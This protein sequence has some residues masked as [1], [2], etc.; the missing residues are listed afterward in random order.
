MLH[1]NI[2][3]VILLTETFRSWMSD[4]TDWNLQVLDECYY[5]LKPSGPGWDMSDTTDWNLQVRDEWYYWLKP[6]GPG[7]VILLTET[8][9]SWMRHEWYYWLKPSG[10]GWVILLTETF[11]SWMSAAGKQLL[12]ILL[13][14]ILFCSF[15]FYPLFFCWKKLAV[16]GLLLAYKCVKEFV[17]FFSIRV[18]TAVWKE[19]RRLNEN[20]FWHSLFVCLFLLCTLSLLKIGCCCLFALVWLCIAVWKEGNGPKDK[21]LALTFYNPAKYVTLAVLQ[22]GLWR[23]SQ[24]SQNQFYLRQVVF[25]CRGKHGADD[26]RMQLQYAQGSNAPRELNTELL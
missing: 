4:T 1:S 22:H 5:W 20:P 19:G 23:C 3:V 8:F 17:C 7:W 14:G 18:C 16:A 13:C 24:Q 15:L 6:S 10:P 26:D 11:R 21:T 12:E 2:I 25:T 9:R